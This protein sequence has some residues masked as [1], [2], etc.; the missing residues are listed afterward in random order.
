MGCGQAGQFILARRPQNMLHYCLL[1]LNWPETSPSMDLIWTFFS[2]FGGTA[3]MLALA[4]LLFERF[5][6]IQVAK[7]IE[8][9]KAALEQ[10]SSVLKT[11]L[12][13]YAHE[14]N[15]GLSRLDE[16][17]SQAIQALYGLVTKWHELCLEIT[18]PNEPRFPDP[19]MKLRRY[20]NLAT[21]LGKISEDL[22]IKTR[23]T[24]IL[25][26]QAS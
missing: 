10:K 12:S 9:H 8:T 21:S 22:S 15:V 14:Q 13:I 23:D 18:Q 6:D 17:R 20:Y 2:A 24:A 4:W 26:Q 25:F 5:V 1:H 7:A 19:E 3:A 16:Q 11:E